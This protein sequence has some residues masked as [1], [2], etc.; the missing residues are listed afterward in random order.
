MNQKHHILSPFTSPMGVFSPINSGMRNERIP[1]P[2]G[3][4][5][6]VSG[7]DIRIIRDGGDDDYSSGSSCLVYRGHILSGTGIVTGMNVVIKE[8]YPAASGSFFDMKRHSEGYLIAASDVE[9]NSTYRTFRE[10]FRQGLDYQ[11]ELAG[12]NA[13]EISVRPLFVS[14]WGDSLYIISD[15][16]A[17]VPAEKTHKTLKDTLS[18]SVSFAET[19]G[20]LHENGYIMTDIKADNFLWIQKPN[21]V[22]IIDTDSLVPYKDSC[23]LARQ[24]LFANKNHWSPE[25]RFLNTKIKEGT[26]ETELVMLKRS[27]LNPNADRYSMGIFF[28]E[29]FFN[30]LPDFSGQ[31]MCFESKPRYL[32]HMGGSHAGSIRGRSAH[33]ISASRETGTLSDEKVDAFNVQM[34][35][36]INLYGDEIAEAGCSAPLLMQSV[37]HILRRLLI[38]DPWKRKKYGYP[39]DDSIVSDLQTIYT[40]LTSETLVLRREKASANARFA[41]YNLL[42]KHPLFE[43]PFAENGFSPQK[44]GV[45]I[46]GGH[47]MR[48]DMLSAVLSIGQMPDLPLHITL[49]AGDA[50]TFWEEF[51]SD[52]HNPALARAVTW[53]YGNNVDDQ[54]GV[55][56]CHPGN[57]PAEFDPGLVDRPLAH[58]TILTQN[59]DLDSQTSDNGFSVTGEES[60]S[61]KRHENQFPKAGYYILLEEDARKMGAWIREISSFALRRKQKTLISFLYTENRSTQTVLSGENPFLTFSPI[62]TESFTENYSEKM[63]SEKIYRMGF[64]AHAYYCG[65]MQQDAGDSPSVDLKTLEQQYRNDIYNITSSERCA[66]HGVY[67]LAGL[68]IDKNYPGRF[69]HY[70]RKVED[71][72]TLEELAWIEHLSW[73]AFM[74]TSGAVPVSME[75]F[76]SYAYQGDNDWKDKRDTGHLHHPLLAA[77]ARYARCTLQNIRKTNEVTPEIYGLL[78]PL[79]KISVQIARWYDSHREFYRKKYLKWFSALSSLC[80]EKSRLAFQKNT[81]EADCILYLQEE[82]GGSVS[83]CD[84]PAAKRI[85]SV[86]C[87]IKNSGLACIDKMGI[88]LRKQDPLYRNIWEETFGQLSLLFEDPLY[89]NIGTEDIVDLLEYGKKRIMKPVFDALECRDFKQSDRNLAFAVIDIIA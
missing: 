32:I 25:L 87:I 78:D 7:T 31:D 4:I 22:R 57:R 77:S 20:I 42:E 60:C 35:E 49:A 18:F 84:I 9:T 58:L 59:L 30:R 12:S 39:N 37:L 2:A 64:M 88:E 6:P 26:P 69:L 46:I 13:M 82:T 44:L 54:T 16:H 17:G 3:T 85:E 21:S 70:Y 51:I 63:F 24:P 72:D 52:V 86:L 47:A 80:K 1:M 5:L 83:S 41:A 15:A 19:M 62:S 27:M 61:R 66:L 8:F 55:I 38:Y 75:K 79:D 23:R 48:P 67:K 71:A 76:D 28:F 40:Q 14:E 53:D 73:T 33:V 56:P 89:Q 65:A 74:L 45:A 34:E 50:D 36:L 11:K 81:D 68:G 10:Q 43:Y 29:L